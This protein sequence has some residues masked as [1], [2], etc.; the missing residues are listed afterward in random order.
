VAAEALVLAALRR[1]G[2][3][4]RRIRP[5]AADVVR[6]DADNG[7]TFALR[8][9][10]RSD[11]AFGD[12][13]LEIA[14]MA[15]LRS[16]T[17]IRPPE[18]VP[19]LDGALI[20]DVQVPE[21]Q[22]P[23][24]CVLFGW[25]PGPTLAARLTLENVYLLGELSARLHTHAATF[26][27]PVALSERTLDQLIGRGE[28][29]VLFSHKHPAFLPPAR[30]AL[31]E[32]VAE[33]FQ[34]TV[35]ALQADRTGRQVIHADL[36]PK[37]VKVHRG[38]LRPLDFYE[39]IWGYAVQDVALT[40]YDLRF[41]TNSRPH[42]YAALR[43]AFQRGY[44]ACLPWPET[45]AGQIDT[46]VAGR[47]LRQANWVLLHETA[48]FASHPETVPDPGELHPFFQRLETEFRALFD[49]IP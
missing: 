27:P 26:H 23:C 4:P 19:G 12:I 16:D 7:R 22:E 25:M 20:Q 39:V 36:H 45:Q 24:D 18:P 15:A 43:D 33:R 32:R 42:G 35:A 14:W 13:P 48:L 47:R 34:A 38:R 2:V 49:G 44:A 30:R 37:N 21:A 29:E 5:L 28:R 8:C 3:R 41:F 11:R 9:R 1:Y 46:L 31:F 6:V 40:L 10:P 17:N